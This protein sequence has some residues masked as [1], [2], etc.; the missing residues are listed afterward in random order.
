MPDKTKLSRHESRELAYK[1]IFA[2]DFNREENPEDLYNTYI[3]ESGELSSEISHE[4]FAGTAGNIE[5]IDIIIQEY[6]PTR[7]VSRIAKAA[8]TALRL[9][10]YEMT[11]E[12]NPTPAVVAINEAMELVK[13]YGDEKSPSFV[14]GVLNK[15]ARDR[16][17]IAETKSMKNE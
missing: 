5:K 7:K 8:V 9:A 6:S 3:E 1:L 13:E 10:I 15:F 17:L 11:R 14:N 2:F 4:L 12:E 16:G